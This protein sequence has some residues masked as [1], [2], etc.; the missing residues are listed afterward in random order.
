[1]CK[2]IFRFV[3]RVLNSPIFF[4]WLTIGFLMFLTVA[5]VDFATD[6]NV[7]ID[8]AK[9][10]KDYTDFLQGDKLLLKHFL[11]VSVSITNKMEI[12]DFFWWSRW[13]I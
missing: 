1:M 3:G 8:I 9:K 2:G 7:A 5:C 6:V 10:H 12:L 4:K 11:T 13:T